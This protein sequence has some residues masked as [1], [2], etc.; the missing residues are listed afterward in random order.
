MP[1]AENVGLTAVDCE[2]PESQLSRR[3]VREAVCLC[4]DRVRRG[5]L[6]DRTVR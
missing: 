6:T 1:G 4:L 3:E 5:L 2:D